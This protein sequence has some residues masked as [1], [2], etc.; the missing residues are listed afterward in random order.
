MSRPSPVHVSAALIF[1]F[2]IYILVV[3]HS[4]P[5]GTRPFFEESHLPNVKWTVSNAI[6]D[7]SKSKSLE[8][9]K[10]IEHATWPTPSTGPNESA[11]N[12][13]DRL[14]HYNTIDEALTD[15]EAW[16]KQ[17]SS[18]FSKP[19]IAKVSMLYGDDP[20]PAYVRALRSHRL[21]NERFN[22]G[23]F[24]LQEDAVG[25]FWNKPLYLLSI[26][27]QELAKAPSERLHWLM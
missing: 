5:A 25:G 14:S 17:S 16:Q 2:L 24:V 7:E 13:D 8:T 23:M 4:S 18:Y 9:T 19:T 10:G 27:M 20:H 21:H 15:N 12:E 3:G 1:I 26:L 11:T 6:Y 22:Y